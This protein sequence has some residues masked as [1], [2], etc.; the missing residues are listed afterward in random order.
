[1]HVMIHSRGADFHYSDLEF[2]TMTRD[3]DMAKG[4]GAKRS[5]VRARQSG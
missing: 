2:L 4:L 1:M 3:I 5:C